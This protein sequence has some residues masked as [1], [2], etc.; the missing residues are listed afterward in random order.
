MFGD[1]DLVEH[2]E[3]RSRQ[4]RG[5]IAGVGA[6]GSGECSVPSSGLSI[7]GV[8]TQGKSSNSEKQSKEN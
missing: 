1:D 7:T 6:N 5:D 2:T 3:T 4:D 8:L